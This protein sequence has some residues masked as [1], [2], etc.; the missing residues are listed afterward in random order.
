MIS[1]LLEAHETIIGRSARRSTRPRA[2]G[3]WGS[4]DLLMGDVLRATSSRSGSCPS[5]S[6][7]CRSSR[8]GGERRPERPAAAAVAET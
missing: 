4:N 6:S 5:T 8:L 3:D 2:Q 1:R 7:R